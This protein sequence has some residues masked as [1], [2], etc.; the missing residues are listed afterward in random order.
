[1]I[2]VGRQ[3]VRDRSCHVPLC[4]LE[5]PES[6]TEVELNVIAFAFHTHPEKYSAL[7]VKIKPIFSRQEVAKM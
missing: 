4:P 3:F 5:S 1:M 2:D 7:G 6:L